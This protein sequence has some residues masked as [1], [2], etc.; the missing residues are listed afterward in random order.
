MAPAKPFQPQYILDTELAAFGLPDPTVQGDILSL[1]QRAS[2]MIDEYCGRT[3]VDGNGSLVYTT[4]VERILLPVGRNIFR[5]SFRPL[6]GVSASVEASLSASGQSLPTNYLD[7][8][9]S[10]NTVSSS[11]GQFGTTA[12]LPFIS[13]SGRYGYA[14]RGQQQVYPD[15]NYA[16]NVLQV[17]SFFGGP[18]AFT[19]IDI[20]S[21]DYDPR[22]GEVW[23][24]AGLYLAQYTEVVLAYNSGFHPLQLPTA[25]KQAC[26]MIARNLLIRAGGVTS[27]KSMRVGVR[28]LTEFT[29]QVI[30]PEVQ[31]MLQPYVTVV[32]M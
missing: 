22:T 9:F 7:T 27:L 26:A 32:A 11:F 4:Y 15:L 10:P 8:G 13:A 5:T 2:S 30:D 25:V 12:L 14:R 20:T 31:R 24:P 19:G 3:D 21:M 28:V 18:P 6:V 16:A 1:V 23:V 29:E 17:A